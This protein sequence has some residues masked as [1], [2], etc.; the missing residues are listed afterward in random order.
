MDKLE[1]LAE[2]IKEEQ[3]NVDNFISTRDEIM[4]KMKKA[5]FESEDT[6]KEF[7]LMCLKRMIIA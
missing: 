5:K 4:E 7:Y 2:E 6:E 3:D 1:K